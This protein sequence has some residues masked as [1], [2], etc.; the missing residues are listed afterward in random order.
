MPVQVD[1][2]TNVTSTLP[3]N[4]SLFLVYFP[5]VT[6]PVT[7]LA[8]ITGGSVYVCFSYINP[9]PSPDDLSGQSTCS[10]VGSGEAHIGT[11]TAYPTY[12]NG[13]SGGGGSS[14]AGSRITL[15]ASLSSVK[16]EFNPDNETCGGNF[17]LSAYYC[18][19]VIAWNITGINGNSGTINNQSGAITFNTTVIGN[20]EYQ[21]CA[22]CPPGTA[23]LSTD[24][25]SPFY[26]ICAASCVGTQQYQDIDTVTGLQTCR[27]CDPSCGSCVAPGGPRSCTSCKAGYALLGNSADPSFTS[28]Y[29]STY[30]GGSST[31]LPSYAS[32]A[33]DV[34]SDTRILPAP[35]SMVNGMTTGRC[36]A[37][38]PPGYAT[39]RS[40]LVPVNG[41]A[42]VNTSLCSGSPTAFAAA[43][44]AV[45]MLMTVCLPSAAYDSMLGRARTSDCRL[46]RGTAWDAHTIGG[47]AIAMGVPPASIFLRSCLQVNNSTGTN[48]TAAGGSAAAIDGE[49]WIWSYADAGAGVGRPSNLTV[50]NAAAALSDYASTSGG[51]NCS[52][53]LTYAYVPGSSPPLMFNTSIGRAFA[54]A[55]ID[56]GRS[57]LLDRANSAADR[58]P[59]TIQQRSAASSL[60]FVYTGSGAAPLASNCSVSGAVNSFTAAVL[61]AACVD[62]ASSIVAPVNYPGVVRINGRLNECPQAPPPNNNN[63]GDGPTLPWAAVIISVPLVLLLCCCATCCTVYCRWRAKR[64]ELVRFHTRMRRSQSMAFRD[65]HGDA[66]AGVQSWQSKDLGSNPY[67]IANPFGSESEKEA[68]ALEMAS[69]NGAK[70]GGA[71]G[72]HRQKSAFGPVRSTS[73]KNMGHGA[74]VVG[75]NDEGCAGEV[76]A[77]SSSSSDGMDASQ[78]EL[79]MRLNLAPIQEEGDG[80]RAVP[81]VDPHGPSMAAVK[82]PLASIAAGSHD[83]TMTAA[84]G[85][86]NSLP[87]LSAEAVEVVMPNPMSTPLT[88]AAARTASASVRLSSVPVTDTVADDWGSGS[89]SG[90]G[91][92][93]RQSVR[94]GA[95]EGVGAAAAARKATL[96]FSQRTM[97]L[98]LPGSISLGMGVQLSNTA[99]VIPPQSAVE[100]AIA[101]TGLQPQKGGGNSSRAARV[102]N[103]MQPIAVPTDHGPAVFNIGVVR[104][105]TEVVQTQT[106]RLRTVND[107]KGD[108]EWAVSKR[109]LMVPS[110]AAASTSTTAGGGLAPGGTSAS[111]AGAGSTGAS[112][113]SA[114]SASATSTAAGSA[115]PWTFTAVVKKEVV[116][117]ERNV[118]AVTVKRY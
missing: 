4:S 9:Q 36:V 37:S 13:T 116:V 82:N 77:S 75:I 86:A 88:L 78:V 53:L 41:D 81:T 96:S 48:T 85:D 52:M 46:Y 74:S 20:P 117:Q 70:N 84:E 42:Q 19:T 32:G 109:T 50:S 15:Y 54:L 17:T 95:M 8:N 2:L 21:R 35:S 7:L 39:N 63:A 47:L 22:E 92:A 71:S 67:A 61:L 110:M 43:E 11:T 115:S 31:I 98:L 65:L 57:N 49:I 105:K 1:D 107:I 102:R 111:G 25:A 6:S 10:V 79:Q 40:V 99:A 90:A 44:A 33:V 59:V 87:P 14:D 76:H 108:A 5:N 56:G 113:D 55:P 58:L 106:V 100:V 112:T 24:P 83:G 38:C 80:G 114:A 62:D 60:P 27:D 64:V 72:L 91:G 26:R 29:W 94:L 66:R 104:T 118:G 23:F 103:A 89:S 93:S 68:S 73:V 69:V 12:A 16:K 30:S 51:C 18:S 28:P 97:E 3:C 45:S 34:S 101:S